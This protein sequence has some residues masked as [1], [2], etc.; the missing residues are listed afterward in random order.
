MSEWLSSRLEILSRY[1]TRS[2]IPMAHAIEMLSADF[3]GGELIAKL[4]IVSCECLGGVF[5]YVEIVEDFA[6]E[7]FCRHN[8]DY[9][10][11]RK[12]GK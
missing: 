5:G 4:A 9:R 6:N 2:T 12:S 1:C 10:S 11:V 7:W 3:P 8:D